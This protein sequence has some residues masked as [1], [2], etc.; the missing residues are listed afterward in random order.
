MTSLQS[1]L[2]G[3][4]CKTKT[5]TGRDAASLWATDIETVVEYCVN[6]VQSLV[7]LYEK[8]AAEKCLGRVAKVSG[9]TT[10]WVPYLPGQIRTV[11]QCLEQHEIC[12]PDTGFLTAPANPK[13]NIEWVRNILCAE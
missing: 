2:V 5:L 11:Y 10:K 6:D 7:R 8:L 9:K 1:L 12:K 4:E 13:D 3:S